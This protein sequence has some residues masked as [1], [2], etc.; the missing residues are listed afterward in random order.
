MEDPR[1]VIGRDSASYVSLARMVILRL[2]WYFFE[3]KMDWMGPVRCFLM[4]WY[5]MV[6]ADREVDGLVSFL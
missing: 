3:F 6:A 4:D 1:K 2:V 5:H